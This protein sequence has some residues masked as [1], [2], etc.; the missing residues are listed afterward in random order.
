MKLY[1]DYSGRHSSHLPDPEKIAQIAEKSFILLHK[2]PTDESILSRIKGFLSLYLRPIAFTAAAAALALVIYNSGFNSKNDSSTA[3]NSDSVKKSNTSEIVN[4]TLSFK[5]VEKSGLKFKSRI[6]QVATLADTHLEAISE[7]EIKM[8]SGKAAFDIVSGNDFRIFVS[9]KFLVRVLGTSFTLTYNASG[10]TVSVS[11]GLVEVVRTDDS[12]SVSLSSNMEQ[13]FPVAVVS[14]LK[15]ERSSLV[16]P[17]IRKTMPISKLSITPD[18]S[19][20]IQ[21]RE[22]LKAGKNGAAVQLFTLEMEKGAEKDKA[23]FEAV[24]IHEGKRNYQDA[25]NL[26]NSHTDIVKASSVYKEEILIKGCFSQ[27]KMKSAD[28]S[29]CKEYVKSFPDGYRKNEI[30]GII[31]E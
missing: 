19:F 10:L 2:K 18:A 25:V 11:K 20:L 15:D 24:K 16:K 26:I 3:Q 9:D 17:K 13:V 22:A 1:E 4:D 31:N 21:G 28:L 7:N 14:T 30:Q 5:G 23:L 12:S 8:N 27:Y 6:A 29:L